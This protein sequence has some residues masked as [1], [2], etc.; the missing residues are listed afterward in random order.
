MAEHLFDPNK[1]AQKIFDAA[2]NLADAST[3]EQRRE[4]ADAFDK[5]R[6]ELC[7]L[8]PTQLNKTLVTVVTR[9]DDAWI[10]RDKN[11]NLESLNF[12]ITDFGF[13]GMDLSCQRKK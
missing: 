10:S 7:G 2:N 12:R 6:N 8:N 11:G 4:S 13:I 9:S 3:K 1:E 5:L